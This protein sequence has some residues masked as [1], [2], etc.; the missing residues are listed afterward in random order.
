MVLIF[1]I[2]LSIAGETHLHT[3]WRVCFGIGIIF[4]VVVFYFRLRMVTSKLCVL[5]V[6]IIVVI[7]A[8]QRQI[9]RGR[10]KTLASKMRGHST[11]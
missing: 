7:I 9:P 6:Y 11:C 8:D 3:V 4:P 10:N 5:L 2:V 1:L